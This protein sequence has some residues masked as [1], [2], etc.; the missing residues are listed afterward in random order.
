MRGY[1]KG[2]MAQAKDPIVEMTEGEAVGRLVALHIDGRYKGRNREERDEFAQAIISILL[3]KSH[4]IGDRH[5]PYRL[6]SE[7]Y[8][9]AVC[10]VVED[11]DDAPQQS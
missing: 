10:E 5:D 6:L 9:E 2:I 11:R 4:E 7:S 1:W 3:S 8:R